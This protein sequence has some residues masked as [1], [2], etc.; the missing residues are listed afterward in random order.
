MNEIIQELLDQLSS[1]AI[2]EYMDNLECLTDV[3]VDNLISKYEAIIN[4][5]PDN[6]YRHSNGSE[7]GFTYDALS[8]LPELY[9]RK[10]E[11]E[12]ARKALLRSIDLSERF[13]NEVLYEVFQSDDHW[14]LGMVY[15][16]LGQIDTALACLESSIKFSMSYQAFLFTSLCYRKK[17]D[18]KEARTNLAMAKTLKALLYSRYKIL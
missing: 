2:T 12:K 14:Q 1:E 17:R 18:L 13:N 8:F 16:L 7:Y 15:Y 10:K 9:I 11:Y 6:N 4:L 3:Q 5:D